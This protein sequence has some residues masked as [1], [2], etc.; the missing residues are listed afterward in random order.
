MFLLDDLLLAPFKGVF[1]VIREIHEAAKQEKINEADDIRNR[2]S[3]L[4]MLLET[5]QITEQEFDDQEREL[6]DRLDELEAA[7]QAD[8]SEQSLDEE[9]EAD[10]EDQLEDED[11]DEVISASSEEEQEEQRD[12]DDLEAKE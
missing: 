10:A 2:L 11:E 3:E 6:L 7:G 12:E 5:K 8:D 9:S 1:A 4:Y